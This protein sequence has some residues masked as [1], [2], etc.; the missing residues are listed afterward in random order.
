MAET[1]TP[2][3]RIEWRSYEGGSWSSFAVY[4]EDAIER[5]TAELRRSGREVYVNRF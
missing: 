5:R 1:M 2:I 3:A 4:T